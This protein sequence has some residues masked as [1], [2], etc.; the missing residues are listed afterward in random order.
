MK[1]TLAFFL[2][3]V[4]FGFSIVVNSIDIH[5]S[6]VINGTYIKDDDEHNTLVVQ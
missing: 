5:A 2:G 6:S 4:I 1:R 3:F